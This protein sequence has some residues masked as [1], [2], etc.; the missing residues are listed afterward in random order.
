MSFTSSIVKEF[1]YRLLDHVLDVSSGAPKRSTIGIMGNQRKPMNSFSRGYLWGAIT[2]KI[3]VLLLLGTSV[4][5]LGT[6][7]LLLGTMFYY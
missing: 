4:L 3:I 5:L 1:I 7:L 2:A 6:S